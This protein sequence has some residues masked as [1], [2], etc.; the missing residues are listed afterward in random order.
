[1]SPLSFEKHTVVITGAGGGL[2]KAYSL[3]FASRGANVVVNDVSKD[4]ADRVVAEI[5]KAGGKAIANTSSVADGAAVIKSAVDAFGG[6]TILIN[7]AGILRDKGFKN[8]SDQEWD[9]IQLVHL[10]GAFACTKAAW[11]IFR[12]QKFGRIINTA[13]AAGIYGNFGQANY[14]AAKMGLIG[15]TKTLAREGAKY[16][17]KSTAIAPIAASPMTETVMPPEMLA[18]LKPEFVVPLVAALTHPNGPDASGKV[19]EVGAGF[20]AEIRWERSKGAI[21]KTDYTFTPSAVRERWA[22]VTDFSNATHPNGMGDT[23]LQALLEESKQL[24]ENKQ[25]SPA[26]RFDN[27]T[28]IV[29]GAGAGLGRVYSL[30]FASLGANVVVNDVSEKG[31]NAVVD[32]I[33]KAGGKA[34]AVVCS[35]ENGEAL[36]KG[37]LDAFKGVHV[38][39]ANAGILRDKSF[40]AMSEKEWDDVIQVH[41]RG[42]YKGAKAVW[43]IFQ[44]QKYGRILTTASSV[45]I[46]GNFGQAN[47]STA[48]AAIIG[49]TKSLAIEGRKYGIFA[50]VLAPSAGT[51]MTQT[52]W[53]QEMVEMFKPEFVAPIVGYL[54]SQANESTTGRLFEVTGGWAAETRWQRSGGYGFPHNK[55]LTPEAVV[56]KW[57]IIT[58]FD[59]RATHPTSTQEAL[60]QI[61]ENFGNNATT[62]DDDHESFIDPEDPPVVVEAKK[63]KIEPSEFTY[64]EKDVILYNLGIGATEKDLQWVFEND[65]NFQALPTFGVIP[66]FPA[67]AGLGFDWVP[68]FNPAKLLHGEQ[69]LEIKGAIPTSG[70]LINE[71][72]LLEVLDKGK[73]T[74]VT[75][76][77]YTKDKAS[78]KLVFENQSTVVLRGSGG[79]G[80]K[81]T[82][83]DRGAASAANVPPK[84]APDAVVEERTLSSQ[85]ALYRLSGDANP[86]HIQPE[87]AAIGGFDRPILHGLAFFGFAGKHVLQTYGEF[88]D[89]KARFSGSVYPGETL[90]TEMWKEGDK[91]IFVT[92]VKERGTICLS[93]AAATLKEGRSKI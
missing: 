30:M 70:T 38:L 20:V 21:F 65:D 59:D 73:Q 4:A 71:V 92:K 35:A 58:R 76:I 43:P 22:E 39:V 87:F 74:A 44:Q 62:S 85:A 15:F 13:S 89:I 37:A 45:G 54:T 56:S 26:V 27:Q 49:F 19:F 42:T 5:T 25:S 75:A 90:V 81:K 55:E 64:T 2:G 11:P 51:A 18:G 41:L 47:Y 78:G 79:F 53:P 50:N 9:A 69:Y 66:Q 29:T 1:M 17:I 7:N 52:I 68:N 72:K 23:N 84:R 60:Q 91:V 40:T 57:E 48:K 14:S 46:Y 12:K 36:V 3:F 77:V 28:V 93:A 82:G 67:S 24:P 61:V 31:A 63:R 6:I 34:V 83:K 8:M 16:N 10:K 33:V 88:K 80:G 32:D 86:L